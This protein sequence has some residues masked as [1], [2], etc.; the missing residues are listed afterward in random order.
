MMCGYN[1][2][3]RA[4]ERPQSSLFQSNLGTISRVLRGFLVLDP[5]P[6]QRFEGAGLFRDPRLCVHGIAVFIDGLASATSSSSSDAGRAEGWV[7][8][9]RAAAFVSAGRASAL[10]SAGRA[11]ALA[12]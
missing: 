12:S 2:Y 10:V 6:P 8:A 1:R 9:A 5:L 7:E 4:R 3:G 11:A